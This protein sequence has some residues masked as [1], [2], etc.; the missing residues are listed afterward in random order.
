MH[1]PFFSQNLTH[2]R[3]HLLSYWIRFCPCVKAE[4][5]FTSCKKYDLFVGQ[6]KDQLCEFVIDDRTPLRWR[7]LCHEDH[8][9]DARTYKKH[10]FWDEHAYNDTI[11]VLL[12]S[13]KLPNQTRVGLSS[14]RNALCV[15]F[16]L[17]TWVAPYAYLIASIDSV[18]Y[19]STIEHVNDYILVSGWLNMMVDL[20]HCLLREPTSPRMHTSRSHVR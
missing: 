3:S 9:N 8:Y 12:K 16:V 10:D 15:K 18:T 14:Q 1:C 20:G 4:P 17:V 5:N 7:K 6:A 2:S 13:P 11:Y 19:P